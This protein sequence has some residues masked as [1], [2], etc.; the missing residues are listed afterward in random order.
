MSVVYRA[1]DRVRGIEVALKVVHAKYLNDE[2]ALARFAREARV[3][4]GLEHQNIVRTYEL[5]ELS[6]DS[7]ALVMQFVD[8]RTLRQ[9]L[10]ELGRLPVT[11]AERI[12]RDIADA[13]SYAHRRGIVHRDVKPENIFIDSSGIALLSDFGIALSLDAE[14]H[15]TCPP[16]RSTTST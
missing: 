15:V 2:D 12:L 10:R 8:G 7:L 4:L 1:R 9:T 3:A 13:L 11:R 16:S 14:S 5:R 6:G